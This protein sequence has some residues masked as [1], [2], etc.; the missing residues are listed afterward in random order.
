MHD[1]IRACFI[2][3]MIYCLAL[4]LRPTRN[5]PFFVTS[6]SRNEVHKMCYTTIGIVM[7]GSST[8]FHGMRQLLCSCNCGQKVSSVDFIFD[9]Y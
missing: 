7:K 2:K 9:F 1:T 8:S 4:I 6:I 5:G 3:S